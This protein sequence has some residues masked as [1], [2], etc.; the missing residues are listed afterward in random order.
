MEFGK[1]LKKLLDAKN[2]TEYRLS[3]VTGISK[4]TINALVHGASKK[5]NS[6]TLEKI[7]RALEINVSILLGE[8]ELSDIVIKEVGKESK[9]LFNKGHESDYSEEELELA[10][11]I[12]DIFRKRKK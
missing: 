8:N 4:S 5:P 2:M 7:A 10:F 3:K 11:E 9:V 6:E 1:R 12:I